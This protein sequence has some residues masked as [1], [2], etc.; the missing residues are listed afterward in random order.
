MD[1]S[2]IY[3][4][5]AVIVN[6]LFWLDTILIGVPLL[7]LPFISDYLS[8]VPGGPWGGVLRTPDL[9]FILVQL[10]LLLLVLISFLIGLWLWVKTRD[11]LV[12]KGMIFSL[13]TLL[14]IAV[15]IYVNWTRCD[16]TPCPP[17]PL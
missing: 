10:F 7:R 5:F 1:K 3:F 15:L 14:L 8:L 4:K 9:T 12:L 17:N 16:R 13:I 11:R 6:I 2:K